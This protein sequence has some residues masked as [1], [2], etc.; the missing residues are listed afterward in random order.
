MYCKQ[1]P[2]SKYCTGHFKFKRRNNSS[3]WFYNYHQKS[4]QRLYNFYI[5]FRLNDSCGPDILIHVGFY[6]YL[7][8]K[9]NFALENLV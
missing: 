5:I 4:K 8:F 7:S 3:Q 6:R 9:L 2:L 1:S